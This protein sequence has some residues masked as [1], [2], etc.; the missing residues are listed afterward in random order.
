MKKQKT[1]KAWVYC[2]RHNPPRWKW[3]CF[4]F[5]GVKMEGSTKT[6]TG[7]KC[8]AKR[9]IERLSCKAT[10]KILWPSKC[11]IKIS[12]ERVLALQR[13]EKCN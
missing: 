7:A 9:T 1:I 4:P 10:V 13:G 5:L 2:D 12:K 3:F 6:S 11:G 8:A